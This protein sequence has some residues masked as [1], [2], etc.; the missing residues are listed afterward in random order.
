MSTALSRSASDTRRASAEAYC[1]A[2]PVVMVSMLAP[3]GAG[4]I[5]YH[6]EAVPDPGLVWR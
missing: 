2:G 5:G 6:P 1:E 4:G 3:R